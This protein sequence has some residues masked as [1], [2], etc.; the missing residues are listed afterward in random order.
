M[1]GG[2][3]IDIDDD[4][5]RRVEAEILM[6]ETVQRSREQARGGEQKERERGLYDDQ[7]FARKRGGACGCATDSAESFDGIDAGCHPGGCEAK[8]DSGQKRDGA[9]EGEYGKRGRRAHRDGDP[10]G[11]AREDEAKD[12][13]SAGIGESESRAAAEKRKQDGFGERLADEARRAGA[14]CHAERDLATF[15]E[16][17]D[18]HEV[19]DVGAGDQKHERGN[20]HQDIEPVFVIPP[21]VGNACASGAKVQRLP[22]EFSTFVGL[23]LTPVGAEPLLQFNTHLGF[24]GKR[25]RAGSHAADEVEPVKGVVVEIVVGL[26]V[27]LGVEREEEVGRRIAERIPVESRGSDADDGEWLLVQIE[28]GAY[29]GWIGAVTFRPEAI[30]DDRDGGGVRLIVGGRE[31][32]SGIS[33]DAEHAEVVARDEF[34]VLALSGLAVARATDREIRPARLESGE[35]GKAFCVVTEVLVEIVGDERKFAV[36]LRVAS[37]VA[38]AWLFAEAEEFFWFCHRKRFDQNGVD[39]SEDRGRGTDT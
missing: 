16:A 26:D 39:Q 15:A 2:A 33:V 12:Q 36:D 35:L 17:A 1:P 7:G 22:G 10:A 34:A 14:E 27:G 20:G 4:A 13:R 38:T 24:N 6:L 30:T 21:H 5:M 37:E 18:E 28:N 8:R 31:Y 25:S 19:G 29:Y 9:G 32:P 3:R 23:H 11:T